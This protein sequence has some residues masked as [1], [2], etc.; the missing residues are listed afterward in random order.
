VI[1]TITLIDINKAINNQIKKAIGG[2]EYSKVLIVAEDL[3][4]P[5]IRP[6]FKVEIDS[7][8]NGLINAVCREKDITVRVYYFATDLRKYKIENMKV[9]DILENAF[10][11]DLEIRKGFFIPIF[12]VESETSDTVLI[13]SFELSITEEL[14]EPTM[15]EFGE[16]IENME[17]LKINLLKEE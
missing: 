10:L 9:Q 3:S 15:N 13:S 14:P 7:N 6:S 1:I 17:E 4:E 11:E 16:I 8:S 2:T 12:D 5:I